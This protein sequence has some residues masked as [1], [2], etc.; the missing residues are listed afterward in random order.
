L[1]ENTIIIPIYNDWKS[2]NK[3]LAEINRNINSSDI[4]KVLII[5]DC[6]IQKIDIENTNLD[7]I[8]EIK[9]LSLKENLGS[10]KSISIGLNYL[11]IPNNDFYIIIMDGD[12][13]DNPSE[14]KQMI[15]TAKINSDCI[16]TS[17]RKDRNEN[18]II[19]FSYKLH[20][21]ISFLFTWHWVSFG[22]F[23]CFNSKNLCKLDLNDIWYA[24]SAGVLKSCEI[25]KLYASRQ[26]RYFESSKVNFIELVEHSFR[27]ISVFY[28]RMFISSLILSFIVYLF[29][30]KLSFLIYSIIILFNLLV[31]LIKI[32]NYKKPSIDL[33]S[34]IGNIKIL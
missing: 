11:N 12:G 18:F 19:K 26:K 14:I 24:H 21:I 33:N 15:T 6:S 2:L 16:V 1:S 31:L 25:K 28:K 3:L 5:D 22:N 4:Y 9:I 32:K 23:S 30:A 20:L 29:T 17:H 27:I 8:K 10:Q 13:E 34:F 7:K